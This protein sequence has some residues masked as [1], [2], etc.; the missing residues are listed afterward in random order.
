MVRVNRLPTGKQATHHAWWNGNVCE[1]V[2]GDE[3]SCRQT[4]G[5]LP[6]ALRSTAVT[7]ASSIFTMFN[8]PDPV[9]VKKAA[10]VPPTG[11]YCG[12][13]QCCL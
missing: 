4:D 3:Y 6:R 1:L 9:E 2:S 11:V 8:T 10:T 12:I 13:Q 5:P 7:W